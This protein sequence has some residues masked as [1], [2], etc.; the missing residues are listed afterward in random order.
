MDDKVLVF[1][2]TTTLLTVFG[3]AAKS[4]T[5]LLLWTIWSGRVTI[6]DAVLME[7]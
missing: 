3:S 7:G 6:H 4:V 5:A 1:T 2:L